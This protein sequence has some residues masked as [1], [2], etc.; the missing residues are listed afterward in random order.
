MDFDDMIWL[1][2]KLNLPVTKYAL[3][4][5]DESQD[6]NKAQQ[7]LALRA[8]KR[9][10]FV[11]D[12]NQS[13]YGFAGADAESMA[14]LETQLVNSEAGCRLLP[15]TV[16]R[17]CGKAIVAEAQRLVPEF[18]AH[19]SN[20]EGK[21]TTAPFGTPTGTGQSYV[22]SVNDGDMIIC[23]VNAPLVSQCFRF[24]KQNRK[25][26]IQGK[27]MIAGLISTV[28]KMKAKNIPDLVEKLDK[29]FHAEEEKE[30]KKCNPSEARLIALQDR[31]DC[32]NVFASNVES[33]DE[34]INKIKTVFVD[35]DTIK[36]IKLSSIHKA[37][38]LEA[39]RV[40][41]LMPANAPC[42]HPMAKTA[43]AIK[44]EHHLVYVGITRAIKELTYV[45]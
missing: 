32:L 35:D 26:T 11:G 6:L 42:P 15:L 17:R 43:W 18:E 1:P 29:W 31:V 14:N 16:T 39:D 5:V 7:A 38:G 33:V 8:G 22:D 20:G 41:F 25:A 9:L 30:L 24:I 27:D 13:I 45:K 4:M 37:K 12:V 28:K 44:Q 3:L 19:E 2:I 23:R 40:F 36:G 34:M 10:I 21:V